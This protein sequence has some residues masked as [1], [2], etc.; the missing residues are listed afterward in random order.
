MRVFLALSLANLFA[1]SLPIIGL[2][3]A[4]AFLMVIL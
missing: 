3:W 4:R 2:V 1:S